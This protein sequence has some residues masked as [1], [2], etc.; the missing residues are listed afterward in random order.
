[1]SR[2]ADHHLSLS[3]RTINNSHDRILA[4]THYA[5]PKASTRLDLNRVPRAAEVSD[6]FEEDDNDQDAIDL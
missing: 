3:N 6:H 1:V 5:R 2:P 4:T